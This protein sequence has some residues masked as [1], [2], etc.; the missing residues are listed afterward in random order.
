MV[1]T[2]TGNRLYSDYVDIQGRGDGGVLEHMYVPSKKGVKVVG[3]A[4]YVNAWSPD[5]MTLQS[6]SCSTFLAGES[7]NVQTA[8]TKF[9]KTHRVCLTECSFSE[10]SD[11][12]KAALVRSE[13]TLYQRSLLP[14]MYADMIATGGHIHL[15]N[16]TPTEA[17]CRAAIMSAMSSISAYGGGPGAIV[18]DLSYSG[19]AIAGLGGLVQPANQLTI[20]DGYGPNPLGSVGGYNIYP[21][22]TN[23]ATADTTPIQVLAIV[24]AKNGFAYAHTGN[25]PQM[26]FNFTELTPDFNGT[27]SLVSRACIGYKTLSDTLVYYITIE[28]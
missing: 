21:T 6:A 5:D 26:G 22:P 1:C 3:G 11:G 18:M 28:S 10:L 13:I 2:N 19:I 27:N 15:G 9:E 7:C 20:A 14:L 25:E 23:L 16:A 8:L 4:V 24:F 17:L 12:D